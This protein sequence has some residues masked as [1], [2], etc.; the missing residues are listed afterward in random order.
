MLSSYKDE[1]DKT[2][3]SL[4]RGNMSLLMQ[5]FP[6]LADDAKTFNKQIE[7]ATQLL[8][9][10][11]TVSVDRNDPKKKVN[12]RLKRIRLSDEERSLHFSHKQKEYKVEVAEK[13]LELEEWYDDFLTF[14]GRSPNEQE[15]S[16]KLNEIQDELKELDSRINPDL[17]FKDGPDDVVLCG[18]ILIKNE[19]NW[20]SVQEKQAVCLFSAFQWAIRK[21]N[22]TIGIMTSNTQEELKMSLSG[23][24]AETATVSI[25]ITSDI[26]VVDTEKEEHQEADEM[27]DVLKNAYSTLCDTKDEENEQ[28]KYTLGHIYT[29][30]KHMSCKRGKNWAQNN[31]TFSMHFAPL[32]GVTPHS[33]ESAISRVA[34]EIK[35]VSLDNMASHVAK[36]KDEFPFKKFEKEQLWIDIYADA[37]Q[38]MPLTPC[39]T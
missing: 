27:D 2:S 25:P 18:R 3:T 26:T 33:I 20:D 39:T 10:L 1:L 36:L 24:S 5:L 23:I 6:H 9:E 4:P 11:R 32:I 35:E 37:L 16:K 21:R 31:R 14:D 19:I 29:V 7:S 12:D 38:L 30:L 22:E 8:S 13:L 17:F 34:N 15:F 28:K